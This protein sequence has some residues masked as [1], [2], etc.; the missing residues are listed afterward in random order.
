MHDSTRHDLESKIT[1]LEH[2]VDALNG[3]LLDQS[4]EFELLEA[5]LERLERR[6]EL[7]TSAGEPE[8]DPLDERPPHY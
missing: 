5:R 7:L 2:T 4:R 8:G 3:A 1:F 6:L